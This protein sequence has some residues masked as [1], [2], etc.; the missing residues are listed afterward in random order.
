VVAIS[1][2]FIAPCSRL[3]L[4][5]QL[6]QTYHAANEPSRDRR[7]LL[8]LISFAGPI[9]AQSSQSNSAKQPS[10][11]VEIVLHQALLAA[12]QIT[13]PIDKSIALQNIAALFIQAG[14][15]ESATNIQGSPTDQWAK[16]N[17]T[18]SF[19][20]SAAANSKLAEALSIAQRIN[21]KNLA[22][23]SLGAISGL[24]AVSGD[25]AGARAALNS[26]QDP[27]VR[28]HTRTRLRYGGT[29]QQ[30]F[31]IRPGFAHRVG[32]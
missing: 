3:R 1:R 32:N 24:R 15:S 9:S 14:D 23:Q 31:Q 5:Y 10:K 16:D 27:S 30:T 4:V 6:H 26:I 11:E 20:Y 8:A 13:A 29:R 25:L 12:Q 28:P 22:E 19:A 7:F 17:V 21:S 18:Y 2:I